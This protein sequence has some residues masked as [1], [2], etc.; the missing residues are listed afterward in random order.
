VG[1]IG[2]MSITSEQRKAKDDRGQ[3]MDSKAERICLR[4]RLQKGGIPWE[5]A[6]RIGDEIRSVKQMDRLYASVEDEACRD[7]LFAPL[8]VDLCGGM[9]LAGT[10]SGW[11]AA[12]HRVWF[13]A[14]SDPCLARERFDQLCHLVEDHALLLDKLHS[15]LSSDAA[16]DAL[17]SSQQ[18]LDAELKRTVSIELPSEHM[19]CFSSDSDGQH[20]FFELKVLDKQQQIPSIMMQTKAGPYRSS[21]LLVFLLDGENFVRRLQD[22]LSDDEECIAAARKVA[23]TLKQDLCTVIASGDATV[24][25]IR[26]MDCALDK[27]AKQNGFRAET[28]VLGK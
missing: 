15:G 10:A 23:R 4:D 14:H 24:I 12:I 22:A 1:A 27:A 2:L 13:S 6:S 20:T 11:S 16:L 25:L 8:V 26:G 19:D 17:L 3:R 21:R 9:K 18:L 7:R 5:L 28:R